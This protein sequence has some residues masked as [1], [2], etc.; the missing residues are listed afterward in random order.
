VTQQVWW[1]ATRSAGLMTWF[2]ATASVAVGLLLASRALGRRPSGPWLL[3]LHRYLGGLTVVFLV[4]HIVTLWADSYVH[5]G[6]A[7]LFVPMASSWRPGAVAWGVVAAWLVFAIEISSLLRDRLP[8]RIWHGIHLGA[9]PVMIMGTVHA[10]QAGSDVRNVLVL[11]VGGLMTLGVA[12]LSIQ[13]LLL[14]ARAQASS[15]HRRQS[16]ARSREPTAGPEPSAVT[17]RW[18]ATVPARPAP[19]PA[20]AVVDASVP[21]RPVPSPACGA[22]EASAAAPACGGRDPAPHL[23]RLAPAQPARLGPRPIASRPPGP[24]P[25]ARARGPRPAVPPGTGAGPE[26]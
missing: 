10:W 21:A 14:R 8:R 13:R 18:P 5:F 6:W 9:F 15:R 7:E 24:R 2:S 3:D 4:I 19:A 16:L 22:V 20:C 25:I 11:A 1:Y 26:R 17:P 12:G 23:R